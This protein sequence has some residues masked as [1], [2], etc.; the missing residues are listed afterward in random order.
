[1]LSYFFFFFFKQ[2]TAYE[3]QVCLEFRRVL[4]R[5]RRAIGE[6]VP[7][8][9]PPA[10]H[11][12]TA[13]PKTRR[14]R[15][16]HRKTPP[17]S[18]LRSPAADFVRLAGCTALL[19][20]FFPDTPPEPRERQGRWARSPAAAPPPAPCAVAKSSIRSQRRARTR[21]LLQPSSYRTPRTVSAR[22]ARV[23]S[24]PRSWPRAACSPN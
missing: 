2:K 13:R 24:K 1:M 4:F 23:S 16:T 12:S 5:S 19:R 3:I 6:P 7:I 10:R 14:D 18:S 17:A 9:G 20:P 15:K 11:V 8:G 22:H 21:S